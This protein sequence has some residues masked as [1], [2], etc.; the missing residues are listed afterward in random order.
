MNDIITTM[1]PFYAPLCVRL[2]WKC[3][4][5]SPDRSSLRYDVL[6]NMIR[7]LFLNFHPA[8]WDFHPTPR[9]CG[10]CWWR[11]WCSKNVHRTYVGAHSRPLTC[12][13]NFFFLFSCAVQATQYF[14]TINTISQIYLESRISWHRV[15]DLFALVCLL[16]K[17]GNTLFSTD[18]YL[19]RTILGASNRVHT[20]W[21]C[22]TVPLPLSSSLA[23]KLAP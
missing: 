14:P 19:V 2:R 18:D 16:L 6:V 10:W 22:P 4:I 1:S 5:I 13:S 3:Q 7:T 11:C 9:Y 17:I 12:Y 15:S 23:A 21:N 20:S 8:H